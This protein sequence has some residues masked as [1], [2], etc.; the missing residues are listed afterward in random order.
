MTN[1]H[2]PTQHE[3]FLNFNYGKVVTGSNNPDEAVAIFD[4]QGR[5]SHKRCEG[6][7]TLAQATDLVETQD[8]Y[9]SYFF[10]SSGF[11]ISF[12]DPW[13]FL[14]DGKYLM[15]CV[16]GKQVWVVIDNNRPFVFTPDCPHFDLVKEIVT[17]QTATKANNVFAIGTNS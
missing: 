5:L 15:A 12:N 17:A 8:A 3:Y 6:E 2:F 4:L 9:V 14:S 13:H 7:L 11:R 1:K 16:L 10:G